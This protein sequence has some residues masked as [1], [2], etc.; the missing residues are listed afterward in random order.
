VHAE[1]TDGGVVGFVGGR[2]D[3]PARDSSDSETRRPRAI[4]HAR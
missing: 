4:R 1:G 2:F 3:A